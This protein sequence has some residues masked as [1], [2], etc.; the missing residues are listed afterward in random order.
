MI[1]CGA[2][3]PNLALNG[4]SQERGNKLMLNAKAPIDSIDGIWKL[5][6][7][8][9]RTCKARSL[10]AHLLHLIEE[11]SY[12]LRTNQREYHVKKGDLIYY[13][14]SET[15]ESFGDHTETVFFSVGFTSDT[16]KPL[17]L[18]CR[19]LNA[20]GKLKT[21]FRELYDASLIPDCT[22]RTLLLFSGLSEILAAIRQIV[23]Q[24]QLSPEAE[25][26]WWQVENALCCQRNFRPTIDELCKMAHCSRSTIVRLC[27]K[28]TGIPPLARLQQ[29]RM[30]EAKALLAHSTLNVTQ[31][32]G[33]LGYPR[34]H[35]FSRE[36]SSYCG[37][38]PSALRHR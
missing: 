27:R 26:P 8:P 31:I 9:Y 13:Y 4:S 7:A 12:R 1:Y 24:S 10:P 19:V 29:I 23:P 11:G 17:P 30:S 14:G 6:G 34:M 35:E 21:M 32:A 33:Y 28:A 2:Y 20:T 18:D 15:V 25:N 5:S 36:F 22:R 38:P 16:F 37:K 3:S